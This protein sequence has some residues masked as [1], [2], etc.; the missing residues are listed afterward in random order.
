[1]KGM[2]SNDS[3]VS[4][5]KDNSPILMIGKSKES[6]FNINA[7]I[8]ANKKQSTGGLAESSSLPSIT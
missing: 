1:M 3:I 5:E 7:K 8:M 4:E 2:F 6:S